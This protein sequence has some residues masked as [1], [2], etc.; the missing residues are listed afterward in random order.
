MSV[1]NVTGSGHCGTF[2]TVCS[3]QA[4]IV[5]RAGRRRRAVFP[6]NG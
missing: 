5:Y 3:L 4:A 1:V 2:K 6:V